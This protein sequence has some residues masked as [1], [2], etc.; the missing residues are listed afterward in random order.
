MGVRQIPGT[1][2]EKIKARSAVYIALGQGRLH[3]QP[4][5]V[6][7][8]EP[9]D[10]HHEDYTKPLDVQWLCHVHHCEA[11]GITDL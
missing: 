7:G 10:A 2:Q 1:K 5:Q 9:A 11:H 3:R 4:C 6:C 8:A